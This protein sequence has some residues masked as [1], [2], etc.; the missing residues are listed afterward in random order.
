MSL[1]T[2]SIDLVAQLASLQTGMDK[3]GRIAEKQ[4]AQ[5]EARYARMSALAASVGAALGGAISIAGITQFLRST[6]DGVDALND[7]SDATGASI[8]NIS[9]LEDIAART[10]TTMDTVGSALVKL[11]KVLAEA[12]P[13][14]PMA[15]ALQ[16]I[17]LNATELRKLDPA[18]ALRRT[19]VALAG[20]ADDGNKARLVQELF[21]KSIRE[22]APLLK[23]LADAGQ[24]NATVTTE[25][26]KAAEEF[27]KQ[28]FA[29][30]KNVVDAARSI[31]GPLV[32]AMNDFIGRAKQASDES[33][34]FGERLQSLFGAAKSLG[35]GAL[36]G[37]SN[38]E[39]SALQQAQVELKNIEKALARQ[40]ISEQ[41]R[42]DLEKQR[43]ARLQIIAKLQS[44]DIYSNEGRNASRPS[45]PAIPEAP[46]KTGGAA[47]RERSFVSNS[48]DQATIAALRAM[49]ATDANKLRELNLALSG[50]FELQRETRGD[51]VVVQ[52]IAKV[53]AEIEALTNA[54][55]PDP[56]PTKA[57]ADALAALGGTSVAQIREVSAALDELFKMRDVGLDSPELEAAI[58]ALSDKLA[59]LK[60]PLAEVNAFAQEAGRNIQDALGDSV[61]KALEG[62]TNDIAKLWQSML[63]R[64]IAQTAAA[65]LGKM[66]LGDYAKTGQMGGWAGELSKWIGSLSARADGG[67]MTAGRPYLVGERGPEIVV[68]RRAGTVLP[69]GVGMGGGS[70]TVNV[71]INMAGGS[72]GGQSTALQA[73]EA[74]GRQVR[75]ALA[76]NG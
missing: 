76:R 64:L 38:N 48:F 2:L 60:K 66:L 30:N 8:E 15:R 7:L 46:K 57:Y 6:I 54:P 56:G 14:S 69:N 29:F 20:Y 22:V 19:A 75:L 27:N 4:A 39:L 67:P 68:P 31:S 45:V 11:N 51:P 16:A 25:Q 28:M 59:E 70:R 74:I 9:A 61:L 10:G 65:E 34:G 58:Q 55:V 36:L 33:K 32:N 3:A 42:A 63:N 72:G 1:A 37:L 52:A 53:R 47:A 41:W 13:N 5:I 43:I 50:L 73:G 35:F 12:D 18:E 17:G 24:L 40:N 21:G 71:T 44:E 26:A 23:D 49:E 62:N